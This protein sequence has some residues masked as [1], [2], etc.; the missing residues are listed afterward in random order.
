MLLKDIIFTQLAHGLQR[1]AA[2]TCSRY[3][4]TY[5]NMGKP[6]PGPTKY[7]RHPW[8]VEMQDTESSWVG[9]KS[10]QMGFTEAALNRS[11][12]TIDIKRIGVLYLLP[13]LNPDAID[14]S[15][16]RFDGAL[17]ISPH[18]KELFSSTRNVGHK[19]AGNVSFYLRGT[20]S[21]SSVKSVSVG[22]LVL[23]ELD[24][25]VQANITQAK[26]RLSGQ[27][28]KQIIQISTPTIPN[29]GIDKA[30]QG[31]T[32]EH[33]YFKCPNC[34]R[35]TTLNFP[36]SLVI[37][38]DNPDSPEIKRSYIKTGNCNHALVHEDKPNW[39]KSGRWIP[40]G[41]PKAF[42][43]GFY[44]NQLYSSTVAPWE[45]AQKSL[46]AIYD[47]A[48][49]QE[50]WN[51]KGGLPHVVAGA[52][53]DDVMLDSCIGQ[54]SIKQPYAAGRVVTMG[55]DVGYKWLN[56]WIDEWFIPTNPGPDLNTNSLPRTIRF[57]KVAEFSELEP[58]M[59]ENQVQGC[60]IDA[61]PEHRK[62]YEFAIRF[63]G[64]VW[65][66]Y[67]GRG[68][69]KNSIKNTEDD[70]RAITVNRTSWLDL[71]IGRFKK[72]KKGIVLPHDISTEL[73]ENIKALI[74]VPGYD[75]DGNPTAKY[76]NNGADHYG[77]AR[78]YSEIALPLSI[79]KIHNQDVGAFL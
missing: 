19:Q 59:R 76:V 67:Y 75:A 29:F 49:E 52:K 15:K 57:G 51:S 32:K 14:F 69:K 55:V 74:R 46:Q 41:D 1:S 16:D 13:K 30:Y 12:F 25:M 17:E 43:R 11:F 10:A 28:E 39:L 36:D 78:N 71:S 7:D 6:F 72:G 40:T 70:D 50:Y 58:L 9:P 54:H 27:L 18:L 73:R 22:L 34:S 37:A 2:T 42:D 33:F 24:E 62:A 21:K 35:L 31:T 8:Q 77:H 47:P 4:S 64:H 5:R 45:V 3:A 38:G 56:Y 44:I 79:S 61:N 20:R 53:I 23:D 66:C 65:L 48:I 68:I 63:D 60:V 26:E